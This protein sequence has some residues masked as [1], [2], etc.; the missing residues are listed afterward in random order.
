M[1]SAPALLENWYQDGNT[2]RT[3]RV[4]AVDEGAD[5]IEVQYFNGDLGEYDFA[6]WSD[7][8]FAAIEP[9]EDWSAP[10]GDLESDDL[11]Y[12]DPDRH[13]RDSA[14]LTLDDL[15]EDDEDY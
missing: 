14:N 6:S 13:R 1:A 11:G 3:F 15:L 5:S 2:G 4:V 10:Y 12:S 9:P 8:P 7:S